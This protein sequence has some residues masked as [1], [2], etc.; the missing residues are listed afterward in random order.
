MSVIVPIYTAIPE[1]GD[2]KAWTVSWGPMVNGDTGA[3]ISS[4][5]AYA[6]RSVQV[7]GTFGS[8]GTVAFEG[9]NDQVNYRTLTSPQGTNLTIIMASLVA[10]VEMA[11]A[12][13]PHVTGGDGTTSLTVT[14]FLRRTTPGA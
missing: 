11:T 2:P 9:S 5:F 3:P 13:R 8:G 14:M 4:M 7:E 10:I 12:Y 6:D 1:P